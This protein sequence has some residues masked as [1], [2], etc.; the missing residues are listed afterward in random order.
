MKAANLR[1]ATAFISST[2]T[3]M[4]HERNLMIYNVLPKVK[5]WALSH[6]IIFDVVDLRWG[7]S[8]EQAKDLHHTIRICLQKV[9]ESDPLFV[10]FLGERYGW[11]PDEKDFHQ[12]MFE[13]D[14]SKYKNLS[15]TELEI[16]Q[17]LDS[18]FFES[19]PK[20]SV[21]LFRQALDFKGIPQN[22]KNKYTEE[23]SSGQLDALK[24]N[25]AKVHPVIHYSAEFTEDRGNYA[26]HNFSADNKLLEDVL[27]ERLKALLTDRYQLTSDN[28]AHES[29]LRRQ[30]YY[31]KQV[32]LLPRVEQCHATMNRC[33]E[34][35]AEY[36][37]GYIGMPSNSAICSQ[38]A[39]FIMDQQAKG[40]H[41]IYRFL[42][43][44][45]R[46]KTVKDMIVSFACELGSSERYRNDP[47][48]ALFFVK[49][50]LESTEDKVL[51]IVTG[52][53]QQM[54]M[55]CIHTFRGLKFN[56]ILFFLE[57][58][59]P[60]ALL[61][62]ID[63]TDDAFMELTRYLLA[64]KAKVLSDRQMDRILEFANKDYSRIKLLVTYLCAFASYETLDEMIAELCTLD[65][66][67]LTSRYLD[68]IV[69]IQDTHWPAGIM[70]DVL[71]LLCHS[72]RP[73]T[74]E[75]IVNVICVSRRIDGEQ[76]E[77]L[78]IREV[79]FSLAFA[80]D[81]IDEY[82]SRFT[83]NDDTLKKVIMFTVIPEMQAPYNLIPNESE[84]IGCLRTLYYYRLEI[85]DGFT[86]NDARNFCEIIKFSSDSYFR[87]MLL[88]NIIKKDEHFYT[89]AKALPQRELIDLF[90]TLAL[91]SMGHD[92]ESYFSM[93]MR[94]ELQLEDVMG[95]TDGIVREK[96][97]SVSRKTHPENEFL[98]YYSA[99]L[100]MKH[101]D[102]ASLDGFSEYI[103]NSLSDAEMG[104]PYFMVPLSRRLKITGNNTTCF[105]MFD[106]NA[107]SYVTRY[108]CCDNGFAII[109]DV[110]TGEM[111]EAFGIPRDCG[112]IV[113]TFYQERT[114]HI[115]F[116]KGV[117]TTIDLLGKKTDSYRFTQEGE[118]IAWI[119]HYPENGRQLAVVND[120]C[121]AFYYALKQCGH[122]QFA[123]G[124]KVLGAYGVPINK[125]NFDALVV[126]AKNKADVPGYYLIDAKQKKVRSSVSLNAE[127]I[128]HMSQDQK[129][130]DIYLRMDDD[131]SLILRYRDE[132]ELELDVASG[133]PHYFDGSCR[134]VQRENDIDCNGQLVSGVDRITGC[135][136][137]KKMYGFVSENNIIYCFDNGY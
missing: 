92:V 26:L 121:V 107:C 59:D 31:L 96:L 97:F 40:T 17:A 137:T 4:V 16:I 42:G 120:N 48:D 100:S 125:E 73:L 111:E 67:S 84:L 29:E 72:P 50:E 133:G 76:E 135:F 91:Q 134:V 52:I 116:R 106:P 78:M 104:K 128:T 87:E 123:D 112:E 8:D 77:K 53:P 65:N 19:D 55:E 24:E 54:L 20:L 9:H 39:Q 23:V 79:D 28:F 32:S 12:G 129:T 15:V 11:I 63:Y 131:L 37:F 71:E 119:T 30:Q 93:M 110:F 21:F 64:Q 5:K 101:E 94:K 90:K 6:G 86:E 34:N 51:L 57:T 75:D 62:Y 98:S 60:D 81:Y 113:A 127:E 14:I 33:L 49:K 3:D 83:V 35:V 47:L 126:I 115:I 130:G 18:A 102:L 69:Q 103:H 7:I 70:R 61:Y 38:I 27:V 58:D 1:Y 132:N 74:W 122:I 99:V 95:T 41:V 117:F 136:A 114:M 108:C 82:D 46:I 25:I 22:V 45:D 109:G 85:G 124:W 44:D 118:T 80:R 13:R 66:V 89:L 88:S 43:I 56:K 2:F 10:C 36:H 68:R 105:T